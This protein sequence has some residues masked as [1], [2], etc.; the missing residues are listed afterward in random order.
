MQGAILTMGFGL[1]LLESILNNHADLISS[2]PELVYLLKHDLLPLVTRFISERLDFSTTARTIRILCILLREHLAELEAEFEVPLSL[3]VYYLEADALTPWRRALAMEAFK[4]VYSHANLATGIYAHFDS[5][6]GRRSIIQDSM[7]TFVRMAAEK[8]SVIGLGKQSSAPQ[9]W[10]GGN[11]SSQE[12]AG[13]E[14]GSA[15]EIMV[16]APGTKLADTVGIS[17][18]WS[19]LKPSCLDSL[20]KLDPPIIPESYVYGLILVCINN[21]VE[22]LAK[23]ILPLTVQSQSKHKIGSND[24]TTSDERQSLD[25]KADSRS[26]NEHN[27]SSTLPSDNDSRAVPVNPLDLH[28][29]RSYGTVQITASLV[30]QC[31]PAI[32]ATFSTFFNASL[33]ADFYRMLIRST[34]KLTQVAGVLRLTIARDAFLTTL[35]KAAVPLNMLHTDILSPS[36]LTPDSPKLGSNNSAFKSVETFFNQVTLDASRRPSMD[37]NAAS[38]NQR[39]LVCLRALINLAIALGPVFDHAWSI[40][41][42][43]LQKADVILSASNSTSSR[44]QR[45]GPNT[46]NRLLED[47]AT[48]SNSLQSEIAAVDAATDRLIESTVDWPDQ[49]FITLLDILCKQI[50]D[51]APP[52]SKIPAS[53]RRA[54]RRMPSMTGI[55]MANASQPQYDKFNISKLGRLV[56]VNVHRFAERSFE[57]GFTT[58]TQALLNVA[59]V[60]SND[61]VFRIMSADLLR[62]LAA[63]LVLITVDVDTALKVQIQIRSLDLL[64]QVILALYNSSPSGA[65]NSNA[66]SLE[67][68]RSILMTVGTI[69]EKCG[70]SLTAGWPT[71]LAIIGSVFRTRKKTELAE[72]DVCESGDDEDEPP[73]IPISTKLV[74]TSFAS[75]QLICSDLFS[76]VPPP[77]LL[78]LINH[79]LY[80]F[81][82]QRKDLNISLTVGTHIYVD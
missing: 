17:M 46:T 49:S 6:T 57:E 14:S 59:T 81:G 21:L 31:W 30:E 26:L 5:Q 76:L 24:L 9:I 56:E 70:E 19:V 13:L 34:Q 62:S 61:R 55:S 1:E 48:G 47:N 77:S 15:A 18:Q 38:L 79:L 66:T 72:E 54:L 25:E 3:L 68:H 28:N 45:P 50:H 52:T 27:E 22:S 60:S 32:L 53:P 11:G 2:H 40:V 23:I 82:S 16:G 64:H 71:I 41:L 7:S 75:V 73:L 12:Q 10:V 74:Q 37:V 78:V 58:L 69:L 29:H 67:V 4:I 8:P 20:D 44:D 65:D 63:E 42:E 51:N 43:T 80:G 39:N 36:A 33:D 35:A